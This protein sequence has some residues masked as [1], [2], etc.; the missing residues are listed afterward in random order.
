MWTD[1]DV[2]KAENMWTLQLGGDLEYRQGA[3]FL[4][5]G[6]RYMWTQDKYVG[7]SK[8]GA[9]NWLVQ[10]KAGINF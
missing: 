10:V 1:V 9:D 5:A 8:E 2:G 7:L 3:L 6:A 4:G